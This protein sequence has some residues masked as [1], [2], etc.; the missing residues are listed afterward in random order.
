[1]LSRKVLL[2]LSER[3]FV[4]VFLVIFSGAAFAVGVY[5]GGDGT[6]ANPFQIRT[7]EQLIELSDHSE[8]WAIHIFFL[9]TNDIDMDPDITGVPAFSDAFIA[10][11][12]DNLIEGFQGVAFDASFNFNGQVISNLNINAPESDYV[13]LF[14]YVNNG[15]IANANIKNVNV[16]GRNYVGGI[17]GDT[18]RT[19]YHYSASGSVKGRDYVGGLVGYVTLN[20]RSLAQCYNSCLVNGKTNIGGLAGYARAIEQSSNSGT[21]NGETNVGGLV[22]TAD[23]NINQSYNLGTVNGETAVGG[24]AGYTSSWSVFSCYNSGVVNGKI[25]VGGLV[26]HNNGSI[27][28]CYSSGEVNGVTTVGGLVGYNENAIYHC[29]SY[30]LVTGSSDV[31]GLVGV[32][33]A[34]NSLW[35]IDASGQSVSSGG[36]GYNTTAMQQL[37]T[38][39]T[40]GWSGGDWSIYEGNDYPRLAWEGI[41]GTIISDP[42]IEMLGHG[43]IE[44]PWQIESVSDLLTINRNTL[45]LSKHYIL[46]NDL[47]LAGVEMVPI[48]NADIYFHGTF[49]GGGHVIRNLTINLPDSDY[50]GL[51]AKLGGEVKR[52]GLENVSVTGKSFVGGLAGTCN[53]RIT[54]C[55]SSGFVIGYK[56]IGGLVGVLTNGRSISDSYSTANVN[57]EIGYVGGFIGESGAAEIARCYSTGIVNGAYEH[58][59]KGFTYSM[60]NDGPGRNGCFWDVDTSGVRNVETDN[61]GVVGLNTDSMKKSRVY[62]HCN[63]SGDIWT[64]DEGKDYPR[65][66]W[67]N[68]TGI[69]MPESTGFKGAGV[70]GDP[71]EIETAVDLR[72]LSFDRFLWGDHYVLTCDID[73]AGMFMTPIGAL[74][75]GETHSASCNGCAFSGSFEGGGHVIS[76]LV[77]DM[78]EYSNVGLFSFISGDAGVR[79]LGLENVNINGNINVGAL[80]GF[81]NAEVSQCFVTGA[82]NGNENVGGIIGWNRGAVSDSYSICFVAGGRLVGGFLG[83]HENG[84][85]ERCY[86]AGIVDGEEFWG[87][88]VGRLYSLSLNPYSGCFWDRT[89]N[90]GLED[91]AFGDIT[92]IE[93]IGTMDMQMVSTFTSAGWDFVGEIVNGDAD[94]WRLCEDGAGYPQLAWEFASYGDFVCGD[95]V[96]M[97]DYDYFAERYLTD[98]CGGIF[99]SSGGIVGFGVLADISAMWLS[100]GCGDCFGADITGDGNVNLSDF[101]RMSGQWLCSSPVNWDRA[102]LDSDGA[103]TDLDFDIWLDYWLGG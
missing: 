7:A 6:E 19:V 27:G 42:Q 56:Y 69:P 68:K 11:D 3:F 62:G 30:G 67:E 58:I 75:P 28:Y 71:Y 44:D 85:L 60:Y 24:L 12:T 88:F 59:T 55:F 79:N 78:P 48:G 17:I 18:I 40:E 31:G 47:D 29:Y 20:S 82:V 14:G 64:I 32:G 77:I 5:D 72:I 16:V 33:A 92:D 53:N 13:G 50:V 38:Y 51:F 9:L 70:A 103:V 102:D 86:N 73:L 4:I 41:A 57:A 76:N 100:A 83:Y 54:Q 89:L 8:D 43:I 80:V 98:G 52:L 22:G 34:E 23:G 37:N 97:D 26:G 21:V 15:H 61:D 2:G 74:Y 65:L 95:G 1:M 10:P 99:D 36:S 39:V 101:D 94:V 46:M 63:W 25:S 66:A 84:P 35:D 93:G 90:A 49:D 96:D 87:G 81:S 91:W 45:F